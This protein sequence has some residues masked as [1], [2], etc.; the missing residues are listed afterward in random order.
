MSTRDL[1]FSRD[2]MER[3]WRAIRPLD[4]TDS[5]D[6]AVAASTLVATLIRCRALDLRRQ[7]QSARPPAPTVAQAFRL[8]SPVPPR[9]PR[10]R[11]PAPTPTPRRPDAKQRAA[12]DLDLGD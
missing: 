12:N 11:R 7:Q 10:R 4:C 1:Y 8:G 6:T 3:A 5:L 9:P 2:E